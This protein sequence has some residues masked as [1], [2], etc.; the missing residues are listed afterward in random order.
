MGKIDDDKSGIIDLTTVVSHE[1]VVV[2]T[3]L[4]FTI[5]GK[6][7]HRSAKG[8]VDNIYL[9]LKRRYTQTGGEQQSLFAALEDAITIQPGKIESIPTGF[10]VMEDQLG[11]RWIP[12]HGHT[13]VSEVS[14]ITAM[15]V[16]HMALLEQRVQVYGGLQSIIE[17]NEINILI[18]NDRPQEYTIKPFDVIG[19]LI[20][21]NSQGIR[22]IHNDTVKA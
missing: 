21:L 6:Y 19:K 15:V 4:D 20:L 11:K 3:S 1:L 9:E 18:L 7:Y 13:A 22:A 10:M 17:N 16:N 12:K 5:P 2:E 14:A 8:F